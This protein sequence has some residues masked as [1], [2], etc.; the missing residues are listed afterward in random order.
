MIQNLFPARGRKRGQPSKTLTAHCQGIQN[1]FPARGRKQ[2]KFADLSGELKN[3]FKTS[4]PQGDGNYD[5][6]TWTPLQP[7]RIQNL[8]PARGRKLFFSVTHY[9]LSFNFDSKPLPRKGTETLA[10]RLGLMQSWQDSK[11]LPRKGTE[12]IKADWPIFVQVV[13]L[14]IQ[15]LFPARGRKHLVRNCLG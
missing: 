7:S 11:P 1:L 3:R 9:G 12:T 13:T 10:I 8:F 5:R 15:N 14:M 4:S 6:A 2:G